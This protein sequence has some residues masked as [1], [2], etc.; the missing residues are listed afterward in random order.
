[1]AMIPGFALCFL[2]G[3]IHRPSPMHVWNLDLHHLS[4][5]GDASSILCGGFIKR[6]LHTYHPP[7]KVRTS[8]FCECSGPVALEEIILYANACDVMDPGH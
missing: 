1:M 3:K 2:G 7:Q 5:G 6:P 4:H 8:S